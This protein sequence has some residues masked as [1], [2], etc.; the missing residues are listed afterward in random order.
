MVWGNYLCSVS[1]SRSLVRSTW[2]V[3]I[4]TCVVARFAAFLKPWVGC[5]CP[6]L[7]SERK[8]KSGV[9]VPVHDMTAGCCL[10]SRGWCR[11]CG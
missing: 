1:K 7:G 8:G 11:Q 5:Q 10:S 6:Q 2:P 4:S 9:N 3:F